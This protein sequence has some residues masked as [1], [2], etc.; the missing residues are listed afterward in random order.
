[1][2][3]QA[4]ARCGN[5]LLIADARFLPVRGPF[6]MCLMIYDS[7]NYMLEA[8]DFA[9]CL[10]EVHHVLRQDGLFIFD[11]TTEYNSKSFFWDEVQFEEKKECAVIRRSW[12]YEKHKTQHNEF[13][14]FIKQANNQY[15]RREE[16]HKQRVYSKAEIQV[17]IQKAGFKLLDCYGDFTFTGP[18]ECSERVHYVLQK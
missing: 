15:E 5:R 1:M 7:I 8:K 9:R 16:H 2:I 11:T 4:R 14:Y 13:I 10:Q 3:R 17:L 6:D 12:Y 18:T